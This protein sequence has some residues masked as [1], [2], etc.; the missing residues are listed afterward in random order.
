[1][2]RAILFDFNGVI[3]DDEPV[4]FRLFQK[5]LGEEGVELSRENYYSRYLGMDDEDCFRAAVKD[6]G[7]GEKELR[8]WEMIQK[9]A[10]D[11]Q[12]E[13]EGPLPFVP[14]V[15]S[16]I[17]ALAKT[18]YLGV[19]SGALRQEIES[20][21][22]RGKV[23][24]CF[25]VLVAAEDVKHG[26]P[27]PE[28]FEMGM[29]NLNRDCVASSELLLPQECLVIEDSLWGIQAAQA[30]DMPSIALTTS[31]SEKDLPGAKVYLKDFSGLDTAKLLEEFV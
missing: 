5:V 29:L 10:V 15:I 4:H 18:H 23:R 9:K 31:Y 17:Q 19:V 26:K 16:F 8:V 6:A 11:Y 12:K 22:V 2:I 20:I 21:L 30:A 27:N 7:K 14:G 24:D 13:M 1:M 3:V 28:G 25:N